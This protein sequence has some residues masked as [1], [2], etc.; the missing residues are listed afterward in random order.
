MYFRIL[1]FTFL[2][3]ISQQ[4]FSQIC[5]SGGVPLS[6]NLG[7]SN[8]GKAKAHRFTDFLQGN[9]VRD[10]FKGNTYLIVGNGDF[11][12]SFELDGDTEILDFHY[13]Y[14]DTEVILEDNEGNEWDIFG[15]AVSGPR[16][17]QLLKA[18]TAF[19]GFWFSIPAFYTTEIY[20][21]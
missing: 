1:F 15:E 10:S 11:I 12:V 16:T 9:I 18:T 14:A 21:N 4:I 3:G 2:F 5:C 19:K 20:S 13:V 17:G 7:L 8:N 6:N